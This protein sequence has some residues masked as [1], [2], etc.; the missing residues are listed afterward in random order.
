MKADEARPQTRDA[1]CQRLYAGQESSLATQQSLHYK[2]SVSV[3]NH[4]PMELTSGR[5]DR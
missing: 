1:R 4:H 2:G 5:S 3:R